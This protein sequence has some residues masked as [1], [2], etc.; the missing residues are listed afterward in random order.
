[1]IWL[2]PFRNGNALT[3]LNMTYITLIPTTENPKMISHGR[4]I[5]HCNVSY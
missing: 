4:P 3:E 1:M 2:N 5:S